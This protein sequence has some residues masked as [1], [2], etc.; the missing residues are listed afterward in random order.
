MAQGLNFILYYA[1]WFAC[2]LG[3]AWGYPWTG[4]LIALA[5]IA[6]HLGLA[7]RRRDELELMLWSGAIG[8]AM[9]TLQIAI[10]TLYFPIGS[11]VS[12]LPPPW[13]IVLWIQFA[14]TFH[15]SMRWLKGRPW[16]AALFGAVGGPLAFAAGRRLDVVQF[17][18]AVWPSLLSLA[19]VWGAVMPLLLAI[20][21]RH[22]GRE[23]LGEYRGA[24][25]PRSKNGGQ[26]ESPN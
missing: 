6:A 2:I 25:S 26:G 18:A 23:G 9:D 11:V 16:I 19:V 7:R 12:W 3:P 20:A 4:T 14:A 10:G 17:H 8:T 22:A 5:L 15:F 1:G 24:L 13:L 21:A